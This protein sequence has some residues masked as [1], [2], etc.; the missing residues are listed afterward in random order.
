MKNVNQKHKVFG[1]E[2]LYPDPKK[3]IRIPWNN[4]QEHWWNETC[5]DIMQVFGLPGHRYTSHPTPDYMDFYFNSQ[6]DADLCKILISE[7]V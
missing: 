1:R 2:F 5:A 6:K 4:Q 7:K 3:T